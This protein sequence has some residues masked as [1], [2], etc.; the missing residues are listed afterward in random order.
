MTSDNNKNMG[1]A[2]TRHRH[3][4]TALDIGDAPTQPGCYI[5]RDAAGQVL[6]IGKARNLRA[7]LRNYINETDSRYS[8]KFLMRRVA[9]VE[10]LVVTSDKEALLLEN[11]LIK[12][13]KPRYNVRLRDDKNYISIRLH[14]GEPFPRLN[15]V[16]RHK[17]DGARYFGPYHDTR[18]AR[19]TMRQ[20]QRLIPLRVCSDHV[21]HNRMRPC[22]YHQMKQ[23]LAPCV[24][25]VSA[26]A[27][28]GLVEQALLV[29]EGRNAEF[30]RDLRQRIKALARELRFEEAAV[31]RDRLRDLLATVEP[32]RAVVGRGAG[33]KDVF[34]FHREGRFMAIQV[35]YYR[36]NAMI[37]G[38]SFFFN[39]AEAPLPELF[40]SFLLQYYSTAP[41]IPRE[42]VVPVA[43]DEQATLD[44]L[45]SE[46]RDGA[47]TIRHPQRGT[48]RTLVSLANKNAQRAFVEQQGKEK[49]LEDALASVRDILR[50]DNSPNRI[51]CFDVSTI[52]GDK[53]VASM[54]VF[55][56]GRPTKKRYRRYEIKRK[57]GQDD[58]EAM[59]EVLRRR[60]TRAIA[61]NDLPDLTLIDGGKGHLGVAVTVLESLGLGALPCAGI[62]KARAGG[63]KS[64]GERFFIPGRMN[65]IVPAQNLSGVLLLARIRDEAHRFAISYHRMKRKKATL[66][67]ALLD[68][69]GV[70]PARARALLAAFGSVSRLRHA[71][72]E[73]LAAVPGISGKLA[74]E[75]MSALRAKK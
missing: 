49:A 14:P 18:A 39:H 46:K 51:E 37:G 55:E 36:N 42:V 28:A 67:S 61:E 73:Q 62:A 58:Y 6:Y 25:L 68:I 15:I 29:L 44:E 56:Q 38:K 19:K 10:F 4:P 3:R 27:Y 13:H 60:Y 35:L 69:P 26:Q 57:E 21:M 30:E 2:S 12:T 48:L 31:L 65:P 22:I 20:L 41:V 47:V 74:T 45:L 53:T 66:S 34:G 70:G 52:Q 8:V 11:S 72:A 7:R 64:D 54:V 71:T 50:L 43:V 32:Q 17:N 75:I 1:G 5:M 40:S 23:C 9:Q 16:R 59:R 63:G 33:D 24:G